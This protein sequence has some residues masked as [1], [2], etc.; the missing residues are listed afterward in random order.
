MLFR[1]VNR[2]YPSG[3]H[4]IKIDSEAI[5]DKMVRRSLWME[6]VILDLSN[7]NRKKCTKGAG[8]DISVMLQ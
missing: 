7:I 6:I 1:Y 3:D 4:V 8:V 5:W 2:E